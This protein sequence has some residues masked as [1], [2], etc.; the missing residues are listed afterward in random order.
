MK[1]TEEQEELLCWSGP[2]PSSHSPIVRDCPIKVSEPAYRLPRRGIRGA[3]TNKNDR[4]STG[5]ADAYSM[6][7][8]VQKQPHDRNVSEDTDKG[9]FRIFD[10]AVHIQIYETRDEEDEEC[11]MTWSGP[12]KTPCSPVQFDKPIHVTDPVYR[13]PRRLTQVLS[14]DKSTHVSEEARLVYDTHEGS[15][16]NFGA[17]ENQQSQKR[18]AAWQQSTPQTVKVQKNPAASKQPRNNSGGVDSQDGHDSGVA[19][20]QSTSHPEEVQ[21]SKKTSK[22]ARSKPGSSEGSHPKNFPTNRTAPTHIPPRDPLLHVP[23]V[24]PPC[25]INPDERQTPATLRSYTHVS[26]SYKTPKYS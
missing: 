19:G 13:L 20:E 18:A 1:I 16:K 17:V 22:R 9:Q 10:E 2:A 25:P 24:T 21:N 23:V 5:S 4:N 7:T 3:V 6:E 11:M 8:D 14:D 26:K 15:T 12:P